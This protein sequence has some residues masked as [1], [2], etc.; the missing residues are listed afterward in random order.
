MS[1]ADVH[2]GDIGTLY[3]AEIRDVG[4]AFDISGASAVY[5]LFKTPDG[6]IERAGTVTTDGSGASQKWYIEYIVI[7]ADIDDGLHAKAGK[8]YQWQGRIEFPTGSVFHTKVNSYVVEPNL[9]V[10]V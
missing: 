9:E 6:V 1:T 8:N 5:L 7:E 4:E 2:V 10:E 3:K